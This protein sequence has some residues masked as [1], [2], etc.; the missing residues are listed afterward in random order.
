MQVL[1]FLIKLAL[2]NH[3]KQFKNPSLKAY[4]VTNHH[5][6][7]ASCAGETLTD[8]ASKSVLEIID[9]FF[10]AFLYHFARSIIV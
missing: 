5:T 4:G 3:V 2:A 9:I 10:K 6:K 8:K 1:D 7:G